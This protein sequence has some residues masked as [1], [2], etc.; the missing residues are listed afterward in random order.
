MPAVALA[1]ECKRR[2]IA[3]PTIATAYQTNLGL[4]ESYRHVRKAYRHQQIYVIG[5]I[6]V[7]AP[8]GEA[9]C[10]LTGIILTGNSSFQ[11]DG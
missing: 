1:S 3:V 9:D 7:T 8:V 4:I 10:T 5:G 6:V 2:I 11:F